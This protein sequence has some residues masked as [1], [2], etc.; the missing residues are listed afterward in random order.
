MQENKQLF[1]K[2]STND[3]ASFSS[4]KKLDIPYF[5]LDPRISASGNNVY[6]AFAAGGE[7]TEEIFF[8]KSKTRV[9]ALAKLSA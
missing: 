6:I 1:F 9:V 4:V 7:E 2:R 5:H 3:G 8:T